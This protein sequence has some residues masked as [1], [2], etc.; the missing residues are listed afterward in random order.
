MLGVGH[1]SEAHMATRTASRIPVDRKIAEAEAR[2]AARMFE[3]IGIEEAGID[4][5]DARMVVA[6]SAAAA[7]VP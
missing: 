5:H 6:R 2:K 1:M 3:T 4:G 7:H